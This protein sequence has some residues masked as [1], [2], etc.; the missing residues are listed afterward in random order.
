MTSGRSRLWYRRLA[1]VAIVAAIPLRLYFFYGYGLGDDMNFATTPINVVESGR[2]DFHDHHTDR[3][4][5]L[6]PQV[7]AF[8][9]LPVGDFSFVLPILVFA[10]ATQIVT[11]GFVR[12]LLG[13][14]A[15]AAVSLL[16]LA[17]PFE[18]L[19]ATSFVPDCILGFYSVA[20][21][22]ACYHGFVRR[23]V[24]AMALGGV[25]LVCTLFV[26]SAATLLFPVFGL[27]T[28]CGRRFPRGWA[29]L[30]TACAMGLAGMCAVYWALAGDPLHWWMH[31]AAPP[32]G[33][34]VTDQ[35]AWTLSVYPKY[36]Y[37]HDPDFGGWMFGITAQLGLLGA[38]IATGVAFRRREP[39]AVTVALG[40]LY[41]LLVNFMPHKIDLTAYYSH[42]RIF[43][44]L[45]QVAPFVYVGAAFLVAWL[46]GRG[47]P[48][49]ML[50]G[51]VTILAVGFGLYQTPRATEPSWDSNADGRAVSEFFRRR[52]PAP[53]AAIHCDFWYCERLHDMHYPE[54]KEWRFDSFT[55]SDADA[56]TAFLERIEDG[57]VITGGA[58]L[59]WYSTREWLFNLG[60]M[61]FLPPADWTLLYERVGSPRRWRREP[62]RIWYVGD[63]RQDEP[64]F[65]PDPGLRACLRDHVAALR[66]A[67][68]AGRPAP[69]TRRLARR[70]VNLECEDYDIM[71]IAG[72]EH[73]TE[74][75]VINLAHNHLR[76]ID[77]SPF[78][79]AKLI[80]LGVNGLE[81]VTGLGRLGALETLWLGGNRLRA[82]DLRGLAR[83][84]DLR[85]D[86]NRLERLDGT[87]ELANLE[88][89]LLG[90]NPDLDCRKLAFPPAVLAKSRCGK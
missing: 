82:V 30:W 41:L 63:A 79:K 32:W 88:L 76:T 18:T 38:M 31:R 69:L 1:W 6:L 65:I 5:M 84:K 21:V 3:P 42:P 10:L 77:L 2:L 89:L 25:L 46:A 36:L 37:G 26:K 68:G 55:S 28:L 58:G 86:E 44:Y 29:A 73:A 8:W 39:P 9:L 51:V 22:W 48:G 35:L 23:R 52:G 87:G 71:D 61:D 64:L 83:L 50:A 57:Y 66:T 12:E 24:G 15:A 70:A 74:V 27:A 43:R 11:M 72:L 81:Q 80:I 47:G 75:K 33:H 20:C 13:E 53:G 59:A 85:L 49:R 62:L 90:T 45:A 54:S 40:L 78:K 16:F 14:G 60:E 34:D 7:L 4:L 17:T 56:K 67:D 19:V